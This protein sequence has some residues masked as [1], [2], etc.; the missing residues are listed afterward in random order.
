MSLT[1]ALATSLSGLTATQT[2]LSV[3]AG[4]VA[5]AQTP[6][7]IAQSAVQ[8]ATVVR[9]R[10][11]RRQHCVDQPPARPIRS[12]AIAFR[13]FR[14]GLRRPEGQFLSAAS[15][16][17]R[18]AR[19]QHIARFGIQQL[20]LC[21]AGIVDV[22]QFVG[23]AKPD[24]RRRASFGAAAQQCDEQHPNAAQPGRPGHRGRCSAG[25]QRPAADREHQSAASGQ[26]LDR[27]HGGFA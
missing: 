24:D 17:L 27:Q 4:N 20:H 21:G 8:V 1:Q 2:S 15:A 25:Q 11:R 12:A 16:N 26:Q 14:R 18:S 19:V 9:R 5:N 7:Y 13:K 6:G 23:G 10:G 3:V 22:A